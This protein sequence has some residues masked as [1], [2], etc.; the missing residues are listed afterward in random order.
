MSSFQ[1]LILRVGADVSGIKQSLY[2]ARKE[3]TG[4]NTFVQNQMTQIGAALT[5][6]VLTL[7]IGTAIQDAVKVEGALEQVKRLM[8]ESADEFIAFS[9]TTSEALGMSRSEALDYGRTYANLTSIFTKS[10]EETMET[11]VELMKASAIVSSA[12]GR[13]MEDVMFRIR[14]GL[15][16]NTEAVEDLGIT[17][18]INMIEASDAMKRFAN[19]KSWNQLEFRLQQQIRHYAIL[20]QV[21]KK[22]GEE[23][24]K[25]TGFRIN[26]F[27]ASLKD[28]RLE[29]G[30]AFLP[31]VNVVLPYLTAF[32]RKM[33]EAMAFV[34]EFSRTLFGVTK[35]QATI[36]KLDNT[37]SSIQN[38]GNDAADSSKKLKGFLAGF[39]EINTVPEPDKGAGLSETNNGMGDPQL[40]SPFVESAEEVK[41]KASEMAQAVR[42]ALTSMS[43]VVSENKDIIVAGLAA[44]G[45]AAVGLSLTFAS[46]GKTSVIAAFFANIKTALAAVGTFLAFLVTPIGLVIIALSALAG[47]FTYLYRTNEEFSTA[48][49]QTFTNLGAYLTDFYNSYVVP[50]AAEAGPV[51]SNAFSAFGTVM[52]DLWNNILVPVGEFLVGAWLS[53]WKGVIAAVTWLYENVFVPFGDFLQMF[54]DMALGPLAMVIGEML[55]AAFKGL[56]F[57]ASILWKNILLPIYTMLTTLFTPA[58]EALSAVFNVIVKILG[59]LGTAFKYVFLILAGTVRLA[60]QALWELAKKVGS[61]FAGPFTSAFTNFGTSAKEVIGSVTKFFKGFL[62]FITGVFT[63]DWKKAFEGIKDM[64]ISIFEAIGNAF[65]FPLNMMIDAINYLV[66]KA[67]SVWALELP[68]WVPEFGGKKIGFQLNEIPK[69]ARGGIVNGPTMAMVG[70]AGPEMIVPLENTSFVDRLASALGTAV[71]S[72]MQMNNGTRSD[73]RDI[74]IKIDGN[75]LARAINPYTTKEAG[76]VGTSVLSIT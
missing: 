66:R 12:T 5:G 54:Y 25:N 56:S 40:K 44:I 1:N 76:R 45:V 32:T 36:K 70:E 65:K 30:N 24:F 71:N 16:G 46:A 3:I 33:T 20:E 62:T 43:Q 17:V 19:G 49:N 42:D 9:K 50:F 34:A 13:T 64:T 41:T 35:S 6:T 23:V 51:L 8:G 10:T 38:I 11:T 18:Y 67:N 59:A 7:G 21:Q 72:A 63:A 15:L 39:D 47:V 60:V 29:L 52:A 68:G 4:F 61:F 57:V 27:S 28:L 74:V 58:F 31:I 14:S 73:N 48:V 69:L 55:V 53:A 75:V 2:R 22:F 37:G 26:Q